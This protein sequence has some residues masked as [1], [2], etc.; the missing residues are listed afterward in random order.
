MWRRVVPDCDLDIDLHD[1]FSVHVEESCTRLTQILTYMTYIVY[2]FSAC[3][4]E[5]YQTVVLEE[6]L[7][8]K[9]VIRMMRQV[10]EGVQ[11]LHDRN[12]VHLDVKVSYTTL[13]SNCVGCH[14]KFSIKGEVSTPNLHQ[15]CM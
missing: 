12:I 5:L 2:I 1:I 14:G 15:M 10:L 3:G 6:R 9:H 8:E 13:H 11:F 4:G 7:H